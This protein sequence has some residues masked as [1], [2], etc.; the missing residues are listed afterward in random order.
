MSLEKAIK[1][2]LLLKPTQFD[3]LYE[4]YINSLVYQKKRFSPIGN[5]KSIQNQILEEIY[6]IVSVT[7]NPTEAGTNLLRMANNSI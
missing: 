5:A 6:K 7:A 3:S 4:L 2:L 1:P